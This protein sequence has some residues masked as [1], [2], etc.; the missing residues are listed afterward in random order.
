M[1][2]IKLPVRLNLN[3]K[4]YQKSI[5]ESV[6]KVA[7]GDRLNAPLLV[8][9]D[10][11]ANCDFSC[12]ECV[13]IDLLNKCSFS[14]D[15]LIELANELVELGVLVVIFVG[16]G[17]PLLH[18]AIGEA[19][20]ILGEANIK[21]GL[22]TN[23]TFINKY[24]EILSKYT[25]WVRVSIDAATAETFELFRPHNSKFNVFNRVIENIRVFKKYN[26][27]CIG[28]S[29]L[30]ITRTNEKGE[31]TESNFREVYQAGV[32]AKEIGCNY[33]EIKPVFDPITHQINSQPSELIQSLQKQMN[34]LSAIE[35]E[36]FHVI[37]PQGLVELIT[38]E[39]MAKL[40]PYG[41]CFICELR[42][43]ITPHGLY[44]CPM[45]RGK[46]RMLYGDINEKSLKEVWLSQKRH[47]LIDSINPFNDCLPKC[48]RHLSNIEIFEISKGD[49]NC[50]IVEDFDL[51]F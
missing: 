43:L 13:S 51:F 29:Y 4:I 40:E 49:F 17:E 30:L 44:I 50:P 35:T 32:L 48:S 45:Y 26:P 14:K 47:K 42:A 18:P 46:E 33:F 37:Y 8:E 25:E 36:N 16:G 15:R 1:A 11:T 7:S 6:Q 20:R 12:P 19:I 2:E 34:K 10:P 5:W 28:Y 9:I 31:I 41:K 21:I 22:I 3:N 27:K 39:Y 23:G 24:A 38:G